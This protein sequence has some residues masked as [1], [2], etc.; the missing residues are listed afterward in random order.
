[1]R[2][3]TFLTP[4][5]LPFR[6]VDLPGQESPKKASRGGVYL[7]PFL[8]I[9]GHID[10]VRRLQIADIVLFQ[11]LLLATDVSKLSARP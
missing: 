5:I 11:E 9:A 8:F 2:R 3:L 6:K 1:M 4:V 7:R 10:L